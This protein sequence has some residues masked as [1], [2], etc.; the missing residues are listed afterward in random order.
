[1]QHRLWDA[2]SSASLP[3]NHPADRRAARSAGAADDDPS[4]RIKLVTTTPLLE[5]RRYDGQ[6][7]EY[8]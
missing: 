8:I 2:S 1:M 7:C 6:L 4:D 3:A 5:G